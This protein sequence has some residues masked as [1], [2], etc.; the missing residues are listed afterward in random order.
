M[1]SAR[2]LLGY[3]VTVLGVLLLLLG[4]M[5]AG[6]WTDLH[7]VAQL[8]ACIGSFVASAAVLALGWRL[9]HDRWS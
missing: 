6:E 5:C 8:A 3:V 4:G 1:I 7:G 2:H 9:L